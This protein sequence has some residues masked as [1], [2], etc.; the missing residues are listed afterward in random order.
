MTHP[1]IQPR[2]PQS[3][4][5]SVELELGTG[6]RAY[7]RWKVLDAI[8]PLVKQSLRDAGQASQARII[9]EWQEGMGYRVD[10]QPETWTLRLSGE[11]WQ[12]L[13]L[14]LRHAGSTGRSMYQ[15][16]LLHRYTE[17]DRDKPVFS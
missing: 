9:F 1:L 11:E 13:S 10:R 7:S 5:E 4:V 2:K 3:G 14:G 15:W 17:S 16:L 12:A 6:S 8:M